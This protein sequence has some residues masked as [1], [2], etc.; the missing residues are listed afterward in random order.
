MENRLVSLLILTVSMLCCTGRNLATVNRCQDCGHTPVPYPLS[1]SPDCGNQHYKVRCHAGSLWFDALNSSSYLITSINPLT[2]RLIIRPP[3]LA[4]NVT[5]M[6]AD[7]KSQGLILDD[8]LPF[9]ITSSN[10]VIGMN[11]SYEMLTLS[12]NCSSNSL[13]HDYI[14]HNAMAASACGCFQICCLFKT[15]G[16]T[17]A[18]KIGVMKERCSAYESFVNLDSFSGPLNSWPES[19]VEM[20]WESPR[21]PECKVSVD[22]RGLSNSECLVD[23]SGQ[24]MC[25]C[26]TGFQWD[27]IN[28]ICQN[29][30]CPNWRPCKLRMK[31][32]SFIGGLI[33]AAVAMLLGAS[34][35]FIVYNRREKKIARAAHFSLTK[36]REDMLNA[37]NNTGKSAK[38]FT[39]KE[40]TRATKNFSKDKVLGAGGFGEVFKGVLDD[41]TI[42]A[43]K[44]AQPGN[45]KGMDQILNEV[46]ILCQVSHRS[47]VRLMGCCLELEQPLLIYE[48][49]PN[50]TLFEH[51]HG[52]YNTANRVSLTWRMR[53]TIAHQ[54][55]E[56]LAYLHDSVTPRIYHRDIKSSNILLDKKLNA[57]VADFGLSRLA[58]AE[59]SHI[60]TCAQGSFG[61]LDPE[62]YLNFQLTDKSDV[63]SYGVVLLELLTS[64]KAID[65]NREEEDVNLVVY[66]KNTLKEERL[67]DAIDPRLKEGAGIVE[68]ETMK[69]FASLALACLDER[70]QNRP[71]MKEVADEIQYIIGIVTNEDSATY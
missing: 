48:Y 35:A 11:C 25:L 34:L 58:V 57:K 16:F 12:K 55:A 70:R 52:N 19:G 38:L 64:K 44:R 20:M 26:K 50:G 53:L 5:C 43:V 9:N 30:K 46:R 27:P 1:T 54:T 56:G 23:R 71:S 39:G 47:L 8:N 42:T 7:F 36:S 67:M 49:I 63:Y 41:G 22:C 3:G 29:L 65:F 31:L 60:T 69:E 21:E 40:I 2:R 37:N 68:L 51:L 62:Y 17:N 28:A 4:N 18:Y 59:S 10:T 6:S 13:C 66:V 15:G 61:Y 14:K 45:T 32:A 33:I 24:R